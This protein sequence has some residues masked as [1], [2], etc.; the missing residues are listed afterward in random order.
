MQNRCRQVSLEK[1]GCGDEVIAALF[2]TDYS[3][4]IDRSLSC[5]PKA[6]DTLLQL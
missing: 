6:E 4:L 5:F 3:S 2:A 1:L